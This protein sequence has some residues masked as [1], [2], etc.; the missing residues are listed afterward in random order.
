MISRSYS[1]LMIGSASAQDFKKAG[2][3]DE[4]AHHPHWWVDPGDI[5]A[6]QVTLLLH[7]KL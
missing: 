4:L 3:E 5:H 6:Y 7:V 2:A 1:L